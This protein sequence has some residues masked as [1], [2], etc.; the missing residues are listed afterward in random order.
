MTVLVTGATSFIGV[1]LCEC[2]MRHGHKVY[3]TARADSANL[4]RLKNLGGVKIVYSDLSDMG[5]IVSALDTDTID[6]FFHLAWEGTAATGRND[7]ALQKKNIDHSLSAIDVAHRLHCRCF[8]MFGSQAEYGRVAGMIEETTPCHPQT[9]Y[10]KAKLEL[11]RRGSERCK[12]LG[13]KY[14]HLRIFSV[15]GVNDHPWTLLSSL[16]DHLVLN[17]EMALSECRQKWNFV[18]IDDAVRQIVALSERAIRSD[19]SACGIYNIASEDTRVLRDFV[20]EVHTL[21]GGSGRLLYGQTDSSN[22]VSIEPSVAK[23]KKT[24]GFI[25]DVSFSEGIKRMIDSKNRQ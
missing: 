19:S 7:A 2:L 18:Y 4:F 22:V 20:E 14:L 12:D 21:S 9:E 15:Y 11:C 5:S 16:V 17:K 25:G 8:V 13:M 3:A 23:L 24:I 6:L 1:A 10:G